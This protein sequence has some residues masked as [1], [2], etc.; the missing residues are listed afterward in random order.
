[1]AS[2]HPSQHYSYCTCHTLQVRASEFKYA[3][4]RTKKKSLHAPLKAISGSIRA[5]V[6]K[7]RVSDRLQTRNDHLCLF[8]CTMMHV[9]WL[10]ESLRPGW[11][12]LHSS[13]LSAVPPLTNDRLLPCLKC[14]HIPLRFGVRSSLCVSRCECSKSYI[15]NLPGYVCKGGPS[16]CE[17]IPRLSYNQHAIRHR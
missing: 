4:S 9:C 5:R 10:L 1:L 12:Y 2:R 16:C 6:R 15:A 14:M 11:I 3:L 7:E 17:V 13:R 8:V